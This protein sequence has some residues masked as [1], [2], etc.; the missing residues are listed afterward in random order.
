MGE[1]VP[2]HGQR[3]GPEEQR[4]QGHWLLAKM[5]KKVLRPGGWEL[6]ETLVKH[7]SI[8]A[9]DDL[10]EFGPGVGKTAE[11]MLRSHPTSYIGVD[12][13]DQVEAS[14]LQVLERYPQARKVAANAMQTGLDDGCASVV[15]GEAML[16]M[17][18]RKE[19]LAIAREAFRL[20]RS[21]GRYAIHELA[22]IPDDCPESVQDEVGKALSLAI[23]VGARP[24][25]VSDW[26]TLLEEAGFRVEMTTTRPM[27][28]LE[29]R[30]LINDEGFFG[31]LRFVFNVARNPAARKRIL[32]MRATFSKHRENLAAIGAIAVKPEA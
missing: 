5:G 4:M 20:L 24:M 32:N 13:N 8:G 6:T 25:T 10:V 17:Q 12:P 23:K 3:K 27:A 22:F 14:L 15:I 11:L 21:G 18:S 2:A 30:R 31:F 1:P 9:K 28:L 29:P 19:K 26:K 7:L 16:T